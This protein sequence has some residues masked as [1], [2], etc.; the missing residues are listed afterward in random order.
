MRLENTARSRLL[1][2]LCSRRHYHQT[3]L[4][5]IHAPRPLPR[6]A[7]NAE[8]LFTIFSNATVSRRPAST[9]LVPVHICLQRPVRILRK[10]PR[11]RARTPPLATLRRRRRQRGRSARRR[12]ACR[13]RVAGPRLRRRL[14]AGA[15][16]GRRTAAAGFRLRL[17]QIGV[18]PYIDQHPTATP[19]V[20]AATIPGS[21]AQARWSSCGVCYLPLCLV[22]VLLVRALLDADFQPPVLG[23]AH[24]LLLHVLLASVRHLV[25]PQ[26][27]VV[28]DVR[29]AAHHDE[30]H[31]ERD[32][33]A[34]HAHLRDRDGETSGES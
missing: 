32:Q 20:S 18:I 2:A 8:L 14:V 9:V 29:A 28:A 25:R 4:C 10:R 1:W 12:T 15:G 5:F 19:F 6:Y 30:E 31:D 23:E 7:S 22:L 13:S 27:D 24:V 21:G 33:V 26:V 16:S 11:N 3:I 34:E 17:S